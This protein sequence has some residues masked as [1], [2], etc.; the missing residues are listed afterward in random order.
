MSYDAQDWANAQRTGDPMATLLLLKLAH[1]HNKQKGQLNPSIPLLMVEMGCSRRTVEDKIKV[2]RG[3]GLITTKRRPYGFDFTLEMRKF[4]VSGGD[5]DTQI[6]TERYAKNS[7]TDTQISTAY[8]ENKE[9]NKE[10]NKE[11]SSR[12]SS[13]RRARDTAQALKAALLTVLSPPIA[14]AIIEHRLQLKGAFTVR[15]A[16]L[17]AKR[18]AAA[19]AICGLTP[20]EAADYQIERGWVGFKPEWVVNARQRDQPRKTGPPNGPGTVADLLSQGGGKNAQTIIDHRDTEFPA[21][22]RAKPGRA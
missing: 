5:P 21:A 16:E 19:K 4:C 2:L 15:A 8:K 12:S 17:L 22:R 6:S 1:H 20:D 7:E 10:K 9:S 18:Y 11:D 3:L 14:D 13:A